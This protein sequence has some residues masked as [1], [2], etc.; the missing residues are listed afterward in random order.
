MRETEGLV[1]GSRGHWPGGCLQLPHELQPG[2]MFRTTG[3]TGL[4][5]GEVLPQKD[6]GRNRGRGK[7]YKRERFVS[8]T[9]RKGI[10]RQQK[11]SGGLGL[12]GLCL[13]CEIWKI[14]MSS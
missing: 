14:C 13:L 12:V 4:M 6:G 2:N 1:Q 7:W 3:T 11:T 8:K 9:R 10:D 5:E